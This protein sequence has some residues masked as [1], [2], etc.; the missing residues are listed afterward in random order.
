MKRGTTS[1][2]KRWSMPCPWKSLKIHRM[3]YLLHNS[4]PDQYVSFLT[5]WLNFQIIAH[6]ARGCNLQNDMVFGK[7][8]AWPLIIPGKFEH[9]SL[10]LHIVHFSWWLISEIY[11]FACQRRL[12]PQVAGTRGI[13]RI[14]LS[15]LRRRVERWD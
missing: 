9:L 8:T 6:I 10:I 14:S 5:H 3:I 15:V 11:I 7:L 12:D 13:V 4:S 2:N 1:L